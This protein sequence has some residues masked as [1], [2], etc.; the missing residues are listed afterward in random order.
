MIAHRGASGERPENTL[1]AYALAVEQGADMI[2]IDLHL[3]RDGAVAVTH[4][5]ALPGVGAVGEASLD[6]LRAVAPELPDLEEVLDAFGARIPFNLELKTGSRGPY[7]GLEEKVREC[8]TRRGLGE[9]ILFSSFD[10]RVLARLRALD[11]SARIGVLVGRRPGAWLERC[12]AVE[13]EA[14]HLRRERAD[15]A[16]V[17]RAH[18]AGLRVHVYTVD[19]P[20]EMRELLRRGVDGLFTNWPARLRALLEEGSPGESASAADRTERA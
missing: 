3:T 12:R 5:E 17:G 15:A 8:V 19:D 9:S 10:D 7:P 11:A 2:E 20:G 13:A 18:A 16:A 1:A 6:A 4:D 14:V